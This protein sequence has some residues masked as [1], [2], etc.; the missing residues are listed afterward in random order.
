[1]TSYGNTKMKKDQLIPIFPIQLHK[2]STNLAG[3]GLA[4]TWGP[5]EQSGSML[6]RKE[7]SRD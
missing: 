4:A 1:M 5:A 6:L 2:S 7:V 3:T